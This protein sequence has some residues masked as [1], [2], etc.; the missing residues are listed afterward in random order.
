MDP[1]VAIEAPLSVN[2]LYLVLVYQFI[3]KTLLDIEKAPKNVGTDI[4]PKWSGTLG[5]I[6]PDRL[7]KSMILPNYL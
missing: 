6:A 3:L 7:P 5:A 1:F 2:F 4:Q